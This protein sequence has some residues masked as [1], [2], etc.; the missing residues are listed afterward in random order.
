MPGDHQQTWGER[1]GEEQEKQR[2][3]LLL[4]P[5]GRVL[6]GAGKGRPSMGTEHIPTP[7][8]V[9]QKPAG[10]RANRLTTLEH[11]K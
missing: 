8:T 2:L 9:T 4:Y 3:D 6:T 5:A 10:W 11:Y 1:L 7:W